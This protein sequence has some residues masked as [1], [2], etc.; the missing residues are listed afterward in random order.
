M[1]KLSFGHTTLLRG[2]HS[3]A[4]IKHTVSGFARRAPR[5]AS[6]M[7]YAGNLRSRCSQNF[8]FFKVSYGV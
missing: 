4:V 3:L 7:V 6:Q 5:T 1:K 2:A 8:N